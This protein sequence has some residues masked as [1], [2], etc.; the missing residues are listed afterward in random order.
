[1]KLAKLFPVL[2]CL[3]LVQNVLAYT[4]L[5]EDGIGEIEEVI[6]DL[7]VEGGG[8]LAG[9]MSAVGATYGTVLR[10]LA[11]AAVM[12]AILLIIQRAKKAVK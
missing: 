3:F 12:G 4:P 9:E 1:M 11:L 2:A 10:L 8:G 6:G 7:L 5:H